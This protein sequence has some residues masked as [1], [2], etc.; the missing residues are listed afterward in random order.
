MELKLFGVF[1]TLSGA[2]L[3]MARTIFYS[4]HTTRTRCD[5]LKALAHAVLGGA[6]PEDLEHPLNKLDN[7]LRRI[8]RSAGK[9][10]A[11]V[12]DAWLAPVTDDKATA[13]LRLSGAS[14]HGEIEEVKPKDM[15]QL[16]KKAEDYSDELARWIGAIE[17]KVRALLEIHRKQQFLALE[18][19][20]TGTP[21]RKS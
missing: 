12:H 7:L 14:S 20:R 4:L 5:M 13:Q 3:L 1:A 9:R 16:A 15:L 11:Y 10:N 6:E 17:D 18:L 19:T 21:R 8:N 2:P